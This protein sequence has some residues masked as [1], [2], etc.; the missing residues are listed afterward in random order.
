MQGLGHKTDQCDKEIWRISRQ[1]HMEIGF[2]LS[3]ES[4]RS[5]VSNLWCLGWVIVWRREGREMEA[6]NRQAV[7]GRGEGSQAQWTQLNIIQPW[8][9]GENNM[10]LAHYFKSI[11]SIK[12]LSKE[13]K[14]FS[15]SVFFLEQDLYWCF[16]LILATIVRWSGTKFCIWHKISGETYATE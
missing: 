5:V 14:K 11:I 2:K 16:N 9:H 15:R 12:L 4:I 6:E 10:W 1:N 13:L 8:Q 7:G 3:P